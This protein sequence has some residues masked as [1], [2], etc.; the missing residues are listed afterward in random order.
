MITINI[1]DAQAR[2]PELLSLVSKGNEIIISGDDIPL[3]KIVPLSAAP[4]KRIS[5][6]NKGRI[7]MSD[8]FDAPL[9]DDFW[10]TIE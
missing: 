1:N 2:L 6:L 7:H 3:A 5:G 9:P 10:A 4:K 8:N